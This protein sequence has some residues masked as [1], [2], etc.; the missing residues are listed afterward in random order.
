MKGQFSTLHSTRVTSLFWLKMDHVELPEALA[1][2]H[3]ALVLQFTDCCLFVYTWLRASLYM[4][5]YLALST[6]RYF[7][8][9]YELD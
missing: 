1:R 6:I 3:S 2:T 5:Y 4:V 8:D 7:K 9:I